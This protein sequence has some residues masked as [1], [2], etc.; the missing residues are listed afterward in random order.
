[1]HSIDICAVM[2]SSVSSGADNPQIINNIMVMQRLLLMLT[3]MISA[4]RFSSFVLNN[5]C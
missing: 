4:E 1:M 5:I 3:I 2:L